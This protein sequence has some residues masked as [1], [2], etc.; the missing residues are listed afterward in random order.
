MESPRHGEICMETE[1]LFLLKASQI[2]S[3]SFSCTITWVGSVVRILAILSAPSYFT[4]SK[5]PLI[6]GILF[7]ESGYIGLIPRY[8]YLLHKSSFSFGPFRYTGNRK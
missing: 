3:L 4:P 6:S 2:F 1:G 7:T 5:L 8:P